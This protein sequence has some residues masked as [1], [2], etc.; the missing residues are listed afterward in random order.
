MSEN[1]NQEG[2]VEVMTKNYCLEKADE[3]RIIGN[4]SQEEAAELITEND[5]WEWADAL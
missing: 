4:E 1:Q 3:L 5:S 2:A